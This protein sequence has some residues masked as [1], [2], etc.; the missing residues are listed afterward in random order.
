MKLTT[1]LTALLIAVLFMSACSKDDTP[2]PCTTLT[3]SATVNEDDSYTLQVAQLLITDGFEETNYVFQLAAVDS[4]CDGATILNLS[5]E[6]SGNIGGTYPVV[7][8]FDAGLEEA[9]G[10]FGTGTI[11]GLNQSFT[12]IQ[13]GSVEIIDNG[14]NNFSINFQGTL[15]N[16]DEVSFAT[17]FY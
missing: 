17:T 1:K 9:S 3:T 12:D 16:N 15:V 4:D 14:N 5:I 11:S 13:S 10:T 8:F 2:T 7:D 6:V